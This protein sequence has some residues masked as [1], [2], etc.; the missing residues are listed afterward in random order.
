MW[1]IK[2]EC[3][4][5][6][7]ALEHWGR[8]SPTRPPN[9]STN[10]YCIVRHDAHRKPV[11]NIFL[12]PQPKALTVITFWNLPMNFSIQ[13]KQLETKTITKPTL[14]QHYNNVRKQQHSGTSENYKNK[15][16][17]MKEEDKSLVAASPTPALRRSE[18]TLLPCHWSQNRE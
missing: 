6:Q 12:S 17:K 10:R 9:K 16:L 4:I 8:R 1:S 15:V 3:S 11:N 2:R 13:S 7:I 14:K 18:S 5:G